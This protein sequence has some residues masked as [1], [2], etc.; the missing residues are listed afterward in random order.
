MLVPQMAAPDVWEECI[1]NAENAMEQ[2]ACVDVEVSDVAQEVTSW[3]RS[4]V[5]TVAPDECLVEAEN[6]LEQAACMSNAEELLECI[7]DAENA[8]EQAAC[9]D[10]H[11]AALQMPSTKIV[12]ERAAA[13]AASAAVAR[14]FQP[15]LNFEV[16]PQRSELCSLPSGAPKD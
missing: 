14:S 8:V 12:I 5:R 16:P 7:V 15:T 9:V 11:E 3:L 13:A 10:P 2:A 6:A 1:V 4:S